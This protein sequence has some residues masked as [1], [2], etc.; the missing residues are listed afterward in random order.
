MAVFPAALDPHDLDVIV[1]HPGITYGGLVCARQLRGEAVLHAM[2]SVLGHFRA[3][4]ARL[5]RYKA[6]PAM[7]HSWPAQDDLYALFRCSA[8]LYRRDLS[9]T[10]EL[11]R[12]QPFS[13]RRRR[14]IKRARAAGLEVVRG[15]EYLEYFWP[16][17]SQ[18]LESRHRSR[19]VHNMEEIRL[20]ADRFPH[21][22]GF[23][24]ARRDA[25]VVGGAVLFQTDTVCHAQYIA[26][27]EA[28]M[29]LGALDLVF[30]TAIGD[31]KAAGRGWF[32]FGIS[33]EEQGRVLNSGLHEFKS[34]FG[35][36][37]LTYD[38]YEVSL[39]PV[40]SSSAGI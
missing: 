38:S 30:D 33:T 28:G 31:A 4:G 3:C 17:L 37:A 25:E 21:E 39:L 10:I 20:L 1:S 11:A 24:G 29:E 2:E 16:I 23:V 19:P 8:H 7:Y 14:G 36:G 9:S 32:D 13:E 5:L 6:V 22:I 12:P 35:G 40:N 26:A 34:G 15:S 27:D 18:T